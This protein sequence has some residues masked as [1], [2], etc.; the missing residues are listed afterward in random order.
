MARRQPAT[1]SLGT[2]LKTW[3]INFVVFALVVGLFQDI[4]SFIALLVVL[5]VVYRV[6]IF[7]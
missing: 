5:W 3:A 6:L 2:F 4:Y 1:E 7:F